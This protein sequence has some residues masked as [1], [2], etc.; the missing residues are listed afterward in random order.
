MR[1]L[2]RIAA[3]LALLGAL[4]PPA[5]GQEAPRIVL[6]APAAEA[7]TLWA[8]A[9]E[10]AAAAAEALGATLEVRQ[11]ASAGAAEAA[12][13]VRAAAEGAPAGIVAAI[14]DADLMAPA[15]HEAAEAGVALVT[16]GEGFDVAQALGA[17]LHVGQDDFE[18]GRAAGEAMRRLG[19]RAA[20]CLAGAPPTLAEDLRCKGVAEAFDWPVELLAVAGAAAEVEEAVGARLEGNSGIEA[21][22]D[23][24]GGSAGEAA[25]AAVAELGRADRVRVAGFDPS[26]GFLVAVAGGQAVFAID[27]QPFL[28]GWLAVALIAGHARTGLMPVANVRTGPRIVTPEAARA[29]RAAE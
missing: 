11:P 12:E 8:A 10:G 25:V 16:I 18:A 13:A 17:R 14:A 2:R 9:R 28:Q 21:V 7:G 29:E 19:A 6:V 3:A 5:G 23:A 26:P 15:V 1:H 22:I 27:Q 24:R 20:L 4:A